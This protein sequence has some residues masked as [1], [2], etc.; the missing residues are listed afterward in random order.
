MQEKFGVQEVN[1]RTRLL[2]AY[3]VLAFPTGESASA[4]DLF[5]AGPGGPLLECYRVDFGETPDEAVSG[6]TRRNIRHAVA[7]R[8]IL[9]CLRQNTKLVSEADAEGAVVLAPE[10]VRR[11]PL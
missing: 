2:E 7:E 5:T 9:Q 10:V 3:R 6:R 4:D 1:A 8:P 11:R